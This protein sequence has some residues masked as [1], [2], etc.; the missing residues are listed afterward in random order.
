[1][2]LTSNSERII[3][4]EQIKPLLEEL[5]K[6]V[7]TTTELLWE[8]L[9]RQAYVDSF[10]QLLQTGALVVL[11]IVSVRGMGCMRRR[12][13][14]DDWDPA[15]LT[16]L[17]LGTIGLCIAWTVAIVYMGNIFTGFFNPEYWALEKILR[18]VGR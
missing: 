11:T 1:M 2:S 7:G 6:E 9:V 10:T 12:A 15:W 18:T 13:R 4:M 3:L 17:I 16:L 8:A 14:E 5:A